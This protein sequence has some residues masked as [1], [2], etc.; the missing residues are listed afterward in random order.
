M[1][2]AV[3]TM[4]P[5]VEELGRSSLQFFW[6]LVRRYK[7]KPSAYIEFVGAMD[8]RMG[9]DGTAYVEAI[10]T[11]T[12]DYFLGIAGWLA[13]VGSERHPDNERLQSLWNSLRPTEWQIAKHKRTDLKHDPDL[14]WTAEN[15]YEY[16][17]Q[18][19]AVRDGKLLGA[20]STMEALVEM[21]GGLPGRGTLVTRMVL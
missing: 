21:L 3:K 5:E 8:E 9:G 17:G 13:H 1:S 4:V 11:I 19:V 18:W 20:A 12:E 15:I 16:W 14:Q 7:V 2:E 6:D 10:M